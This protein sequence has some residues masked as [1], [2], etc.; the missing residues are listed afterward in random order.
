[1]ALW[2][3]SYILCY[4]AIYIIRYLEVGADFKMTTTLC[5]PQYITL[6]SILFLL[7]PLGVR[8]VHLTKV[9]EE[10][11]LHKISLV[12]CC[13]MAVFAV[14]LGIIMLLEALGL[15]HL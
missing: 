6:A 8:T 13:L 2:V 1:M 7:L 12:V 3:A 10:R 4:V 11:K 14:G 15:F 9:A 5:L